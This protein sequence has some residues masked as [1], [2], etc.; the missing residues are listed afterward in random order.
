M[1]STSDIYETLSFTCFPEGD[2]DPRPLKLYNQ[3]CQTAGASKRDL[4]RWYSLFAT[5]ESDSGCSVRHP[6]AED[7]GGNYHSA[8]QVCRL[9]RRR[10]YG[11][12]V[13]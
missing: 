12:S 13:E 4:L 10:Q 3:D 2:R 1:A 8:S 7:L 5:C 6:A 9:E 11:C